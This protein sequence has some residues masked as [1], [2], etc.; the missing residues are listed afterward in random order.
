MN[1]IDLFAGGGGFSEGFVREGFIPVAH[2]EMNADAADTLKTRLAFHYL[3]EAWD[4][5]RKLS[6]LLWKHFEPKDDW[7][8]AGD[9]G[10]F[11]L[12]GVVE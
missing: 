3:N 4:L 11:D 6:R 8:P 1:Y 12:G 7:M 5:T 10:R 9:G 2:V